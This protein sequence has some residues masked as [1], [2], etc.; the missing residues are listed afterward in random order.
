M[1]P[2]CQPK[3]LLAQIGVDKYK[4]YDDERSK[5]F[6]AML[7]GIKHCFAPN[8]TFKC[9][10]NT[11]YNKWITNQVPNVTKLEQ[12]TAGKKKTKRDGDKDFDPLFSINNTFA[13]NEARHE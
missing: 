9:D 5:K 3:G 13:K 8:I 11:S 6:Q 7:V 12:I 4:W 1:L 10:N 2:K